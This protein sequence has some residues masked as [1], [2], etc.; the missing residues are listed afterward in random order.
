M[1][2]KLSVLAFIL[3]LALDYK[4]DQS[5]GTIWQYAVA[6]IAA[7]TVALNVLLLPPIWHS[8]STWV[9]RAILLGGLF[10]VCS[11][12]VARLHDVPWDNYGRMVL[13]IFLLWG[14]F[15]IAVGVLRS[16]DGVQWLTKVLLVGAIVNAIWSVYAALFIKDLEMA[17]IRFQL[18]SMGLDML[19]AYALTRL[20]LDR[21]SMWM[22]FGILLVVFT[23]QAMT[24]TRSY[25]LVWMVLLGVVTYMAMRLR[26]SRIIAPIPV[27]GVLLTATVFA[28]FAMLALGVL[29]NRYS[30]LT[31]WSE[32]IVSKAQDRAI[33][34]VSFALRIAEDRGMLA[35]LSEEPTNF[36]LGRGFGSSFNL[37]RQYFFSNVST[38]LYKGEY[39][40]RVFMGVWQKPDTTWVPI[41]HDGGVFFLG[42][43]MLFYWQPLRAGWRALLDPALPPSL[44]K[45]LLWTVVMMILWVTPSLLGNILFMRFTCGV[46]GVVVAIAATSI[47]IPRRI[48]AP[49]PGPDGSFS[50]RIHP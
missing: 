47:A 14:G 29:E 20:L 36:L 15:I 26:R 17:T 28:L 48:Q 24:I 11:V 34:D 50:S 46:M 2:S 4:S 40:D 10:L 21:G 18:S 49:A 30:T 22:P 31:R 44:R 6:G 42:L 27:A 35:A 45:A 41:I 3:T 25:V 32:R 9:R 33:L 7:S 16:P 39:L 23:V 19:F 38:D 37:D 1:I 5:G 12:G 43:F 8:L 13:P